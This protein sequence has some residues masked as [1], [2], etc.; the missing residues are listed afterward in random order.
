MRCAGRRGGGQRRKPKVVQGGTDREI[1]EAKGGTS[2]IA[3]EENGCK[4]CEQ[5]TVST[6]D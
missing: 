1:G 6:Q 4:Q 5:N 3:G 2:S